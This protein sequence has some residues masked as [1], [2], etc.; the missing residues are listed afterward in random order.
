M[1]M[2]ARMVMRTEALLTLVQWFS[3]GFPV[4]AFGYSHGLEWEIESGAVTDAEAVQSWIADIL[5]QGSGRSDAILLSCAWRADLAELDEL[6]DLSRALAPS[7]ERLAETVDLGR[8][9]VAAVG[10]VW[11]LSLRP[12]AY[13]VAVGAAS[14]AAGLPLGETLRLYLHA[15]A[16]A[17]ISAGVRCIP[18]G[19]TEGQAIL[20]G[21]GGLCDEI[22]A[23]ALTATTDD[24]GSAVFLADVASMR[25][26]TQYSRMFRT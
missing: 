7:S 25:H 26:E 3:P 5:A 10:P 4:G 8:A 1:A 21:F 18:L 13:P 23:E 16:A 19:Q 11:N 20:R 14:R 17:L 9:F 22:A 12:M 24:I 2:G 6:D 15:F